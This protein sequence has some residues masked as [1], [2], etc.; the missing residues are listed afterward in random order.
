MKTTFE[1]V[2]LKEEVRFGSAGCCGRRDSL[3]WS[4]NAAGN[5]YQ[6]HGGRT[7]EYARLP[8]VGKRWE[9]KMESFSQQRAE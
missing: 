1:T 8:E 5:P 6:R 9:Q 2:E 4:R 3:H 7:Q